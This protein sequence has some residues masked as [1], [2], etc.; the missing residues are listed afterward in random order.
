MRGQ[1]L[2]FQTSCHMLDIYQI[3]CTLVTAHYI[4]YLYNLNASQIRPA[5]DHPDLE[6]RASLQVL[7]AKVMIIISEPVEKQ[8]NTLPV[9]ANK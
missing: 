7:S 4:S 3:R 6:S 2:Y 9:Q 8:K 1:D 5:D